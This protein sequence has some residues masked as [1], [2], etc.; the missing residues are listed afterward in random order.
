VQTRQVSGEVDQIW[1]VTHNG[2]VPSPSSRPFIRAVAITLALLLGLSFTPSASAD[3]PPSRILSGWIPY[4]MSSQ[5]KPQGI[6]TATANS[7]LFVDVSPFWYS[8]TKGG[9]NGVKIGF[10]SNFGNAVA[11]SAWA[12]G[13]LR[14]AGIPVIPAIADAS[15]KNTMANLLADPARR[16]AHVTEIVN[17]VMSNNYDGIDLDYE[18]FAFSDGSASWDKTQPNWTAFVTELGTALKAQGKQLVV[19]IPPPCS[20]SSN[21]SART[22][23]YVYNMIGIAP[24]VDRIRIMA[25]DYS[26]SGPLAPYNWVRAI[27]AYSAS[28]VD[29]AKIQIGVPTYGRFWTERKSNGSFNLKGE[30]PSSSSSG[31]EK[32]AYNSLT[33]RGSMTDADIPAFIAK[34]GGVSTWDDTSKENTFPYNKRLDWT[35]SSGTSQTCTAS[36]ILRFGGPEGVLARTQ[37]VGEFG[38]NAAAYW[39]IGGDN[40]AQWPLIRSYAQSLAPAVPSVSVA[41]PSAVVFGQESALTTSATYNGAPIVNATAVLQRSDTG[42]WV[43]VA[44]GVTGPDGAVGIAFTSQTSATH[45]IVVRAT[46]ST[47]EVISEDFPITVTSTVSA[48]SKKKSVPRG[49]T[50]KVPTVVRPAVPQQKVVLQVQRGAQW[51]KITATTTKA[52]G[53]VVIKKKAKLPKG[54]Y[55]FRVLAKA[56]SGIGAGVSGTFTIRIK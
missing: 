42:T 8:A 5:G 41:A 56:K 37:L 22:G 44:S 16:S 23:Y 4:W 51:K 25:Y 40:P 53:R 35:D 13:Q 48:R 55:T 32:A 30:C 43:D 38:I 21:C 29:P 26:L 45:R 7:D 33:A 39:T 2:V 47:P 6:N 9:P 46:E 24:F 31:A 49:N 18:T 34:Q 36:K 50:I 14:A 11:N 17:I 3:S 54:K 19:T 12:L 1:A 10:N 28:V 20:M 27:V 15:G 52:N